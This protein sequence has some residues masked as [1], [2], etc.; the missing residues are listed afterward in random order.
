M[1]I[2]TTYMGLKLKNPI[3]VASCGLSK[4]V[5]SIRKLGDAGAGCIVLKS[6]FEEQVVAETREIEKYVGPSW[7]TEALDYIYPT[8]CQFEL[9]LL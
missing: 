1:D 8:D 9:Y 7:H 2:K 5:D 4:S 6:L 3:I